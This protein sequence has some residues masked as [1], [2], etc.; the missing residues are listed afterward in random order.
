MRNS[1]RTRLTIYFIGVAILPLLLVGVVLTYQSFNVQR[2]QAIASE[3]EVTKRVSTKVQAFMERLESQLH[4]V[5]KSLYGQAALER[6]ALLSELPSYPAIFQ[7][8]SVLN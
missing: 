6:E 5:V 4:T 1:I 3:K 2:G 7:D 8:L